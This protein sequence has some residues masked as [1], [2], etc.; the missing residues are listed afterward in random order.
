MEWDRNRGKAGI[1]HSQATPAR[2]GSKEA[3]LNEYNGTM[4]RGAPNSKE[5]RFVGKAG[6][7]SVP[8]YSLINAWTG[9]HQKLNMTNEEIRDMTDKHKQTLERLERLA[10][11]MSFVLGTREAVVTTTIDPIPFWLASLCMLRC[12]STTPPVK[13]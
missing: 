9:Q 5:T 2:S 3:S 12:T 4:K 7:R 13:I 11:R 6:S 8:T 1:F 10:P